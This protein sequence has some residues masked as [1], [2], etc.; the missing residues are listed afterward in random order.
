MRH[1]SKPDFSPAVEASSTLCGARGRSLGTKHGPDARWDDVFR[2]SRV[3]VVTMEYTRASS[4][5]PSGDDEGLDQDLLISGSIRL[6]DKDGEILV[7]YKP[8]DDTVDPSNMLCAGKDSSSVVEWGQCSAEKVLETQLSYETEWDMINAVSFKKRPCSNGSN[9]EGSLNHSH[10]RSRWHFTF[11]LRELRSVTVKQ[12]GWSVLLFKL[13]DSTSCLPSLHFHQGGSSQF[14]DAVRR[15]ALLSECA[16]D[17]SCLLVSTPN[18]AL[19]QSFENLLDDNN[20]SLVNIVRE[21]GR[22]R[23]RRGKEREREKVEERE[24]RRER[25]ERDRN[26][27]RE[28]SLRRERER[29]REERERERE[30]DGKRE[31][32]GRRERRGRREREREIERERGKRERERGKEREKGEK[33]GKEREKGEERGKRDR[34]RTGEEGK[35]ERR[36]R[37]EGKRERTGKREREKEEGGERGKREIER[38]G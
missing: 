14:L 24:R 29:K 18:K 25:R 7:E 35:R 27:G 36:G 2:E 16:D 3:I 33:R 26:G 8:L 10:E 37:R 23:E 19:S 17:E 34:E 22:E 9:A 15:F 5:H 4:F 21:R 28:R 12:E 13:K 1:G 30:R 20:Y 6:V 11:S 32:K 31:R 38:R